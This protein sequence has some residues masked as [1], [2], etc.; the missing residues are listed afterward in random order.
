MEKKKL[1]YTV[2][3]MKEAL[4][5]SRSTAYELVN[6]ADFPTARIGTRI[7]IPIDSLNE[8]LKRGGTDAR[9]A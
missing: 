4:G 7:F 9:N 2:M 5:I 1:V 3:E 8:W 6:R